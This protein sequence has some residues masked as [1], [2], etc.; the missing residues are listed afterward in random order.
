MLETSVEEV[1]QNTEDKMKKAILATQN[2]LATIRTGRANTKLL[3]RIVVAYYGTPTPL[4]QMANI[5]TPDPQT[6][7][8]QPY[9]KGVMSDIEKA[10]ATS[11][12]G[13]TPN[14]DGQVIRIGIPALTEDRRKDLIKVVK[15][16]TEE[17]KV[18]IR[19]I[20]RDGVD[21][22]KKLEKDQNL[23]EDE[24]KRQQDSVQKLT[25]KYSDQLDKLAED[26]EKEL[27]QV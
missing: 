24:V 2:E 8:I 27:M 1:L 13:L 11:D 14:N 5:S 22:I 25:D 3:D 19:N 21:H 9:D 16:A 26:K 23:P 12:L 18:A 4:S 15:K 10:I 7:V 20:R 17:G 6:L